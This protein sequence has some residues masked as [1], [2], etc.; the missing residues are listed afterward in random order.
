QSWGA[1]CLPRCGAGSIRIRGGKALLVRRRDG[2]L[3]CVRRLVYGRPGWAGRILQG[4]LE[5]C[6][7]GAR[8]CR[9]A[10]SSLPESELW[11]EYR[12]CHRRSTITPH[13]RRI[14]RG[15]CFPF[16]FW[17]HSPLPPAPP[18]AGR[19]KGQ[20]ESNHSV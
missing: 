18:G 20:W 17:F 15:G 16:F 7:I 6:G 4:E 2:A 12:L 8:T 3:L 11:I 13:R 10:S 1:S 5:G 9:S 19:T 14:A